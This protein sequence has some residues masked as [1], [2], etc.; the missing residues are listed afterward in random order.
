MAP[1]Q[2]EAEMG[3]KKANM[4]NIDIEVGK[5]KEKLNAIDPEVGKK[6]EKRSKNETAPV[7]INYIDPEVDKKIEPKPNAKA[8]VKKP[9]APLPFQ[10]GVI[11]FD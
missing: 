8:Q 9:D 7:E 5:K 10:D 2:A 1:E 4:N 6:K 3:K 11:R